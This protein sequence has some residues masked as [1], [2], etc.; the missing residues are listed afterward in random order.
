M[1]GQHIIELS[2]EDYQQVRTALGMAAGALDVITRV[3]DFDRDG[4]RGVLAVI[5]DANATLHR[6]AFKEVK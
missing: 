2:F 5:E 1:A 3:D 4:A 6:C